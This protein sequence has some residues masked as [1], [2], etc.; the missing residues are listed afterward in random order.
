MKFRIIYRMSRLAGIDNAVLKTWL[1]Y[2][3]NDP[4]S[5]LPGTFSASVR[6]RLHALQ[7]FVTDLF[8]D[9]VQHFSQF[10]AGFCHPEAANLE[11]L[12]RQTEG[13][14]CVGV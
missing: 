10:G 11:V 6:L 12:C 9:S 7:L 13:G 3:Q 1:V 8:A 4:T 5:C 2:P 14:E